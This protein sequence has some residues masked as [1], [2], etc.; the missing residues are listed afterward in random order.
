ME[1]YAG[2]E[3]TRSNARFAAAG[4]N[5]HGSHNIIDATGCNV[6]GDYNVVNGNGNNVIGTGNRA[7]GIGNN[8]PEGVRATQGVSKRAV[9]R[10]PHTVPV[11]SSFVQIGSVV[12][13]G[14]SHSMVSSDEGGFHNVQTGPASSTCIIGD[15]NMIGG[16]PVESGGDLAWAIAQSLKQTTARVKPDP[17][18][19]CELTPEIEK[20]LKGGGKSTLETAVDTKVAADHVGEACVVCLENKRLYTLSCGHFCVCATCT[21]VLIKE[22]MPTCPMCRAPIGQTPLKTFM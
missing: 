9:T 7:M 18:Q 13:S 3:V 8:V 1:S 12:G 2:T 21:R 10:H 14:S 6:M 20:M 15:G 17:S 11:G 19:I 16:I 22:K 5:I 4:C